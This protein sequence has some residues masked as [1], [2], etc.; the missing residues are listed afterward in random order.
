MIPLLCDMQGVSL[1]Y[2]IIIMHCYAIITQG[3]LLLIIRYFSLPYLQIVDFYSV[4][5]CCL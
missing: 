2:Y 3:L 4:V 1:H 5:V